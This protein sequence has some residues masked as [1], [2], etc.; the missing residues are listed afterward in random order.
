MLTLGLYVQLTGP[1]GQRMVK[2]P[3]EV[4]PPSLYA[5]WSGGKYPLDDPRFNN[6]LVR[7]SQSKVEQF[8]HEQS[9]LAG[10]PVVCTYR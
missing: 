10:Q 8:V 4:V 5:D 3:P 2:V 7:W 1:F 9:K 6:V